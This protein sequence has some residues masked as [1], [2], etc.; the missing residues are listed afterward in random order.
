M[1]RI[2]PCLRALGRRGRFAAA[3]RLRPAG[4]HHPGL[5]DRTARQR[6]WAD[7]RPTARWKR[8]RPPGDGQASL[9]LL[10]CDGVALLTITGA[11][12]EQVDLRFALPDTDGVRFYNDNLPS[13]KIDYVLTAGEDGSLQYRLDTAYS[14]ALTVTTAEGSDTLIIDCRREL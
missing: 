9:P 14:F 5:A 10:R 2:A 6:R 1:N 12:A 8:P 4:G 7:H 11:G 13:E 3:V